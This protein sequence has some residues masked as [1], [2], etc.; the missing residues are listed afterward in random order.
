MKL[1]FMCSNSNCRTIWNRDPH[2]HCPA[3]K[4]P[5]GS[6]WSCVTYTVRSLIPTEDEYAQLDDVKVIR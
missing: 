5:D 4:K 2:G 3:C 1:V 6:G